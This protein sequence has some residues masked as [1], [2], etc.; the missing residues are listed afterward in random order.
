[1]TTPILNTLFVGIA[2][3]VGLIIFQNRRFKSANHVDNDYSYELLALTK[4]KLLHSQ[5]KW[6]VIIRNLDGFK[7]DYENDDLGKTAYH[8]YTCYK[9]Q[10]IRKQIFVY[11]KNNIENKYLKIIT[12][13]NS[14]SMIGVDHPE[15]GHIGYLSF[16]ELRNN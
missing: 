10:L 12:D 9:E 5:H 13:S 14:E 8:V 1:M 3:I 7:L 16:V 11:I 6:L 2:V 15:D 4:F